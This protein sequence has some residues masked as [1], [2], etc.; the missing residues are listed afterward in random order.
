MAASL[1]EGESVKDAKNHWIDD[2]NFFKNKCQDKVEF[3]DTEL[4]DV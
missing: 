4:S 3:I 1:A 2:I